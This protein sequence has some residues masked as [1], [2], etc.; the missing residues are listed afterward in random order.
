MAKQD[1]S[2]DFCGFH[3]Q[4]PFFLAACPVSRTGE[5]VMRAFE[6]GWGGVVTKSIA[7]DQDLPD[8]SLSPRFCGI[9]PGGGNLK[10]QKNII[11]MGNMDFRIDISV[12]DTFDGF[13]RAKIAYPD[14][15]LIISVKGKFQREEWHKLALLA[16]QAGADAVE[17]CLSCP[18]AGAG[19]SIGQN[20]EALKQV[21]LWMREVIDLPLL[22]KMTP[23]V[24]NSAT[25]AQAAKEAGAVAV[26][27]IN[28]FKGI[29]GINM[30]NALPLPTVLNHSTSVG[31]SGSAVRPMAQYCVYEVAKNDTELQISGVGGVTCAQ[32]AIEYFLLGASTIQVG[33]Q[34][35]HE[36]YRLVKD[37]AEG[38]SRYME[39]HGYHRVSELVGSALPSY[40]LSTEG[41]SR[42]QQLKSNVDQEY[43]IHCGRCYVACRDGAYQAIKFDE[44]REATVSQDDCVG[45]GLCRLVCPVPGAIYFTDETGR[46]DSLN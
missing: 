12:Q 7:L 36:G 31:V 28:T 8:H 26:S 30:E 33:T 40:V 24:T 4:N 23:H 9:R 18:D 19:G 16:K 22:V 25:I 38:L 45:C 15:M 37:M 29:G 21:L 10:L 41:L 42:K 11:G 44:N 13:A 43:C 39:K 5:M 2:I 32:D 3:C 1:L 17:A 14:R 35:M 46:K 27:A 20:P 6:A 34:V